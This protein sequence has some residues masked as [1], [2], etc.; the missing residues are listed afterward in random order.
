MP[1]VSVVIP[2]Y[3]ALPYLDDLP[4]VWAQTYTDF[5]LILVDDCS[6]DGTWERLQSFQAAFPEKEIVLARNE[7]NLGPGGTRNYGLTRCSG[8]YVIFLDGDDHYEPD[9]L[10]KMVAE[11]ERTG[12]DLVCC[13]A[14]MH[15]GAAKVTNLFSPLVCAQVAQFN[16]D[17]GSTA[18]NPFVLR[19]LLFQPSLYPV[20]WNKMVRCELLRTHHIEFPH[21]KLGE[22]KC[23][24]MQVVLAA[25]KIALVNEALYHHLTRPN[26]LSS[27][28]NESALSDIMAMLDFELQ[29]LINNVGYSIYTDVDSKLK[30]ANRST[31]LYDAWYLNYWDTIFSFMERR[32]GPPEWQRHILKCC[33]EFCQQHH[34]DYSLKQLP[35]SQRMGWHRLLPKGAAWAQKRTQLKAQYRLARFLRRFNQLLAAHHLS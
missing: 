35:A 20:P 15:D 34:L 10:E 28:A 19:T 9:F 11:L 6:T 2:L 24:G 22:D 27:A 30:C 21:F 7:R 13:G 31:P 3:N 14:Q 29:A 26:S 4:Q 32:P 1:Q 18:T 23:W 33:L 5:E 16:T 8:Q 25:N 12:A 17:G